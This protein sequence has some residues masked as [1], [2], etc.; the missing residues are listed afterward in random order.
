VSSKPG[1]FW[2][3]EESDQSCTFD[4]GATFRWNILKDAQRKDNYAF[5]GYVSDTLTIPV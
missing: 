3:W 2:I 1:I 5:V 4:S